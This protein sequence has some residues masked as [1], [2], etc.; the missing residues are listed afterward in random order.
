[1]QRE[2]KPRVREVVVNACFGGFS[3]SRAAVLELRKSGRALDEVLSGDLPR[4]DTDLVRVVREMGEKANGSCADLKIVQIPA[5][6]EWTIDE[7]DGNEWVAEKHR[8]W[9][10]EE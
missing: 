8:V 3:L 6:V 10:P 7:Y 5:D 9:N 4:D 2:K 1:M